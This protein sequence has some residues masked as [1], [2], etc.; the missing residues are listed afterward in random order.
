[1]QNRTS[2]FLDLEQYE[3]LNAPSQ[4]VLVKKKIMDIKSIKVLSMKTYLFRWM[5][6]NF[7]LLK[8]I[9]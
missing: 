1:M 9:D 6:P 5:N 7:N 8:V 2:R 4:N 3:A